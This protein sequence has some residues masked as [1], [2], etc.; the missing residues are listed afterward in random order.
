MIM[1]TSFVLF[2]FFQSSLSFTWI[3]FSFLCQST[4]TKHQVSHDEECLYACAIFI[5]H[6]LFNLHRRVIAAYIV[7]SGHFP[8]MCIISNSVIK[9]IWSNIN[10]YTVG[11]VHIAMIF[12]TSHSAIR[13]FWRYIKLFTMEKGSVSEL[14]VISHSVVKLMWTDQHIHSGEHPYSCELCHK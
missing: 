2:F 4:R 5:S 9:I 14:C 12:V 13:M 6:V 10:A 11:S 8:V 1:F 3:F 7:G